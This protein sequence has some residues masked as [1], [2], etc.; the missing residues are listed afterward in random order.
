MGDWGALWHLG[1]A[2]FN[3]AQFKVHFQGI[4]QWNFLGLPFTTNVPVE[5][6]PVALPII[7]SYQLMP[8]F[9]FLN[10]ILCNSALLLDCLSLLPPTMCFLL[11]C[12]LV[13]SSLYTLASCTAC[14]TSCMPVGIMPGLWGD[15]PWRSSTLNVPLFFTAISHDKLL[16]S[17]LSKPKSGVLSP[18]S[19]F[20]YSPFSAFS[21]S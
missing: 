4:Q 19:L 13:S 15:G 14:L 5:A 6:L 11:M 9:G 17:F 12:E 1:H 8:K 3:V 21:W 18:G 10:P 20:C 2:T 7:T 16:A